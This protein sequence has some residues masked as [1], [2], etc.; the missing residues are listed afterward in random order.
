ME[1]SDRLHVPAALPS[2]NPLDMRLDGPQ[3]RC[4]RRGVERNLVALPRIEQLC[5]V[6]LKSQQIASL[7]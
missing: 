5:Y 1:V 7:Q 2:G 3:G 4:E 6:G